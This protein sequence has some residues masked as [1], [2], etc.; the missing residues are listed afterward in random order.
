M[1][2]VFFLLFGLLLPCTTLSMKSPTS[3]HPIQDPEKLFS[4]KPVAPNGY[5]YRALPCDRKCGNR[6][7]YLMKK[8]LRADG[9]PANEEEC[10]QRFIETMNKPE[11][12]I[13]HLCSFEHTD[14]CNDIHESVVLSSLLFKAMVVEAA[15]NQHRNPEVYAALCRKIRQRALATD[16][17]VINVTQ[18]TLSH[19][20]LPFLAWD[21]FICHLRTVLLQEQRIPLLF[22]PCLHQTERVY[23]N[24]RDLEKFIA[25]RNRIDQR[26]NEIAAQF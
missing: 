10:I 1:K 26:Y 16:Q 4:H 15:R 24:F 20:L 12:H 9:T 13:H 5:Y 14:S 22:E 6:F 17:S 21:G 19:D 18:K 8:T 3:S 2:H 23:V 25:M 7:P 11:A